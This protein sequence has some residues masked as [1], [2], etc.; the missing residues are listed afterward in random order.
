MKRVLYLVVTMC[1]LLC[2]LSITSFAKN[3]TYVL[4]ELGMSMAIPDEFVVFTRDID[5]NDPN[6]TEYGLTKDYMETLMLN[7][8]IYLNAWDSTVNHEIVVTMIDSQFEDYNLFSDTMLTTMTSSFAEEYKAIGITVLDTDIYQH[9]QAKFYKVY[10]SQPNNGVNVY[11]LQYHTVYDGKAINITMHSY[12]GVIDENDEAILKRIVDDTH[13]TAPPQKAELPAPTTAFLYEDPTSGI[14]F[15]VPENWVQQEMN[16]EREYLDAKFASNKDEGL[17]ILFSC[18][19]VWSALPASEKSQLTRTEIDNSMLTV[20]DVAEMCE[21]SE[22]NVSVVSFG[23]KEYFQA[24]FS[25]PYS[26]FGFTLSVLRTC[27]IRV[28]NGHMYMFQFSGDSNHA[29]Y[30]DFEQLMNSISYPKTEVSTSQENSPAEQD[31]FHFSIGDFLLS[32]II[33]IVIYSLPVYI[34]RFA[35]VKEPIE[36]KK[37]KRITI[38]YGIVAAV[39]MSIILFITNGNVINGSAIVIWSWVNYRTLT[40][41]KSRYANA[42]QPD[43]RQHTEDTPAHT[44]YVMHERTTCPPEVSSDMHTETA[45]VTPSETDPAVSVEN[46]HSTIS[47]CHKCGN[48]LQAGSLFC[49]KCGAKILANTIR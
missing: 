29:L 19:D 4:D 33:T 41:G 42:I 14:K 40:G 27:L 45:P 38:I 20:A 44:P 1:L 5:D 3:Q 7:G 30:S 47:F 31:G 36:K 15:T 39:V 37:A 17:L 46:A 34:Y 12:N 16:E 11:G 8:N 28:E 9:E 10:I 43:V 24:C 49:H 2:S 13:F 23:G 35:I 18:E 6:L 26:E 25:A 32:I 22:K 21:C 48:K